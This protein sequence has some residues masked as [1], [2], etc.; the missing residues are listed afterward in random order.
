MTKMTPFEA[1]GLEIPDHLFDDFTLEEQ[2][3]IVKVITAYPLTKKKVKMNHQAKAQKLEAQMRK[4]VPARFRSDGM[5]K[6]NIGKG[7]PRRAKKH[8]NDIEW[9]MLGN[10]DVKKAPKT[11]KKLA[12]CLDSWIDAKRAEL[13]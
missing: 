13:A 3:N 10:P 6:I 9:Q 5:V 12:K 8:L 1:A 4:D 7:C 2:Q 11:L